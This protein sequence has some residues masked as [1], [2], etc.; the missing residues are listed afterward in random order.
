M[1]ETKERN[2]I[3]GFLPERSS[4]WESLKYFEKILCEDWE[5][6]QKALIFY[7]NFFSLLSLSQLGIQIS[8][9]QMF[10]HKALDI[11]L[12]NFCFFFDLIRKWTKHNERH[13]SDWFEH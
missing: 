9:I 10:Y 3:D 2:I 8:R 6:R 7:L 5:K 1:E 11:S 13:D 4:E 12:L